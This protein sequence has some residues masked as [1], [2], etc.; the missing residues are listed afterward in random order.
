MK[1]FAIYCSGNASRVF[2]FFKLHDITEYKVDLVFYDGDSE[3]E[4][5][6]IISK[7]K[8]LLR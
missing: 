4:M 3:D 6:L 7:I 8:S 5:L 1:K 2:D